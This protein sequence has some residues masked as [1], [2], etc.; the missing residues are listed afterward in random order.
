MKKKT[1][2]TKSNSPTQIALR[3]IQSER[4]FAAD[5]A[6]VCRLK[7]MAVSRHGPFLE[8]E[9]VTSNSA[10]SHRR[11]NLTDLIGILATTDG[12]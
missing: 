3:I 4:S 7:E 1:R 8:T 11:D 5:R 10:G 9:S 12:A 2:T 6:T